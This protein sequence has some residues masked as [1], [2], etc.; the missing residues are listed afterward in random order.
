VPVCGALRKSS[1][2]A[3]DD[4]KKNGSR[5]IVI[6]SIIL[7]A[8]SI[9]IAVLAPSV[10][11]INV[12]VQVKPLLSNG[13]TGKQLILQNFTFGG[14]SS[15]PVF[16]NAVTNLGT[17]V[18]AIS[19]LNGTNR[20]KLGVTG[21]DTYNRTWQIYGLYPSV[22]TNLSFMTYYTGAY[23]S[24]SVD[25]WFGNTA[26]MFQSSFHIQI[27]YNKDNVYHYAGPGT[28][29]QYTK[30]ALHWNQYRIYFR[31]NYTH[32]VYRDGVLLSAYTSNPYKQPG[33]A[34]SP[35][36]SSWFFVIQQNY[37]VGVGNFYIGAIQQTVAQR[38][39]TPVMPSHMAAMFDD[40]NI[41]TYTVAYPTMETY[42]WVGSSM[43]PGAEVGLVGKM[44]WNDIRNLTFAGWDVGDHSYQHVTLTGLTLSKAQQ[45]ISMGKS[46]IVNNITLLPLTWAAPFFAYNWTLDQYAYALG[47]TSR[48]TA[49]PS[50]SETTT[51]VTGSYYDSR[52]P[53]QAALGLRTPGSIVFHVIQNTSCSTCTSY[54]DWMSILL[55]TKNAGMK[56]VPYSTLLREIAV[57]GT[58]PFSSISS[59]DTA[60]S[61]SYAGSY[62]TKADVFDSYGINP[63]FSRTGETNATTRFGFNHNITVSD[64]SSGDYLSSMTIS[65]AV[66]V[67]G[68]SVSVYY[69][70]P[71]ALTGQS[72]MF[73][74]RG[75]SGGSRTFRIVGL[76]P[77]T[78]YNISSDGLL[79]QRG[80]TDSSGVLSFSN[81]DWTKT[82]F[83]ISVSQ[84]VSIPVTLD[85]TTLT[86]IMFIVVIAILSVIGIQ[87]HPAFFIPDGIVLIFFGMWV[88]T[89]IVSF[90]LSVMLVAAGVFLSAIG[91]FSRP[92][93]KQPVS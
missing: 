67:N 7:F 14:M 92:R 82:D 10:D 65:G 91:A 64:V 54:S 18:T 35:I 3:V 15:V 75:F 90:V 44:T 12:P 63:V 25:V 27:G 50:Y 19:V 33:T 79:F 74:L 22:E 93:P 69:Y 42:G 80:S 51:V 71:S 87:Y 23:G 68:S 41:T 60:Y 62:T 53:V 72:M 30:A 32:D 4:M 37:N 57:T 45:N 28:F 24:P 26:N 9:S 81:S 84:S 77:Y 5:V 34:F 52:R 58:N 21:T 6:L 43:V 49:M 31:G 2:G 89:T 40:A 16:V 83:V 48:D 20:L 38:Q 17:Q 39:I 59:T 46:A 13:F 73:T 61:F 8:L 55:G 86:L 56:M 36:Y 1:I 88:Y 70:E 78:N 29:V 66:P 11:A 47:M 76:A 85:T